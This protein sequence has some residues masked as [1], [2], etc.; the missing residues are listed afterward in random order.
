MK[1]SSILVGLGLSC[2]MRASLKAAGHAGTNP[3]KK[4][5]P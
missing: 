1:S 3:A 4:P 2:A 5:V